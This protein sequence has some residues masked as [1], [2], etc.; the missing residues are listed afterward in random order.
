MNEDIRKAVEYTFGRFLI[1]STA[2]IAQK[3]AFDIPNRQ[4]IVSLDG[5]FYNSKGQMSGGSNGRDDSDMFVKVIEHIALEREL[6]KIRKSRQELERVLDSSDFERKRQI[7]VQCD[8]E[9]QRLTN[10]IKGMTEMA[11]VHGGGAAA[12]IK[13]EKLRSDLEIYKKKISE[14]QKEDTEI[15][16]QVQHLEHARKTADENKKKVE[17]ELFEKEKKAKQDRLAAENVWSAL[18]NLANTRDATL[19]ACTENIRV[20]EQEISKLKDEIAAFEDS[21]QEIESDNGELQTKTKKHEDL[22]QQLKQMNQKKKSLEDQQAAIEK[23]KKSLEVEIEEL[24]GK[25]KKVDGEISKIQSSLPALRREVE[26]ATRKNGSDWLM[27]FDCEND[28]DFQNEFQELLKIVGLSNTS[29]ANDSSANTNKKQGK[30]QKKKASKDEE[31]DENPSKEVETHPT[32]VV[33]KNSFKETPALLEVL[34]NLPSGFR[35][36]IEDL[37]RSQA[38]LRRGFD[39]KSIKRIAELEERH[40]ELTQRR[41]SL[42]QEKEGLEKS[43]LELDMKKKVT[44]ETTYGIVNLHFSNIFSSLLPG[45]MAQLVPVQEGIVAGLDLRVGFNGCWKDGLTE[46]SGGQRSLLALSLILALLKFK[47]APLYILDEVDA[48]LD[49]SHTANIGRMIRDNFPNSQFIVV[50]LKEGMFHNAD[51]L[52]STRFENNVSRVIRSVNNTNERSTNNKVGMGADL[53]NPHLHQQ[54][55]ANQGPSARALANANGGGVK[56]AA[57]KKLLNNN[58][59]VFGNGK[60]NVLS[61][62]NDNANNVSGLSGS[63]SSLLGKLAAR[64]VS[65]QDGLNKKQQLTSKSKA[66]NKSGKNKVVDSEDE[67]MI[68]DEEKEDVSMDSSQEEQEEAAGEDSVDDENENTFTSKTVR[69]ATRRPR[70]VEDSD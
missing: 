41:T 7:Y 60:S 48:A 64:R 13:L 54:L 15:T 12:L 4:N 20:A 9:V 35:P 65:E 51:V 6:N 18:S 1:A 69:K 27:K 31:M 55:L 33:S 58:T 59:S 21:L 66:G 34:N 28:E 49:V 11:A 22:V 45:A 57:A 8:R 17:K 44:V 67:S 70:V 5:T 53:S 42:Q 52:F 2:E 61:S 36:L 40:K 30:N 47:P 68:S 14:L 39:A 56:G 3:V 26:S 23:K 38:K 16:K 19:S 25:I 46:L 37:E 43:I 50:S 24:D 10:I 63:A 29:S 62:K 32:P